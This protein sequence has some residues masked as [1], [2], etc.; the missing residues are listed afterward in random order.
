[1]KRAESQLNDWNIEFEQ[2]SRQGKEND[3]MNDTIKS[4]IDE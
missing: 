1:M 4:K 2:I 3:E